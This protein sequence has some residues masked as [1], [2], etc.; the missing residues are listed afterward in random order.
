MKDQLNWRIVKYNLSY[1]NWQ[2]RSKD[3]ANVYTTS[4]KSDGNFQK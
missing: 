4:E 2:V 3:F 1:N